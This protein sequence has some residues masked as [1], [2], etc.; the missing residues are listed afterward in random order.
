FSVRG[1]LYQFVLAV[2]L[3][4][5]LTFLIITTIGRPRGLSVSTEQGLRT[6][7][8]GGYVAP[9]LAIVL[10]IVSV[11]NEFR[12]KTI[13]TTLLAAGRPRRWLLAKLAVVG[14]LGLLFTT[15][16]QAAVLATGLYGLRSKG[17][18]PD[19]WSGTLR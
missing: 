5:L 15:L 10:G 19:V 13:G 2:G 18:E 9:L 8:G 12:H 4:T 17:V 1:W 6:V 11:T 3:S 14:L 7:F 16:S